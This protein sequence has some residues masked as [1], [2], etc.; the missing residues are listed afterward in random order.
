MGIPEFRRPGALLAAALALGLAQPDAQARPVIHVAAEASATNAWLIDWRAAGR[1]TFVDAQHRREG[2]YTTAG[3]QR[4]INLDQPLAFEYQAIDPDCPEAPQAFRNEVFQV[5]VTRTGGTE[6]RGQSALTQVG[7]VTTLTG[8]NAGRVQPF[9]SLADP[10]VPTRHLDAALR[11]TI[12][13]MVPG[14]VIAGPSEDV[15]PGEFF[16][17]ADLMSVEPGGGRFAATGNLHPLSTTDGWLV[18]DLPG[19]QRAYTRVAVDRHGAETW[20]RADWAGGQPQ[21][22][23]QALMVKPEAGAGFGSLRQASRM[24]E[25]G[26][27]IGSAVTTFG[28]HLYQDGTGVRIARDVQGG[29]ENRQPIT[30]AFDGERI[31]QQRSSGG[32]IGERTWQPLRN[33]GV[34]RYL[35][36]TEVRRMPDGSVQDFIKPR[37]NFYVDTGPAVP[38][39][40]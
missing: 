15:T 23:T 28:I 1:V 22:V 36:E 19:Q 39:A 32:G 2:R 31:V 29:T 25:S 12:A 35:M 14:V 3:A 21:T 37:V 7:A 10:G 9:G 16:P 40:P 8:C 4:V 5:G 26:A 30:W 13:D 38:P 34:R 18:L 27:F 20:L 11:P 6:R 24:W 33:S 17:G